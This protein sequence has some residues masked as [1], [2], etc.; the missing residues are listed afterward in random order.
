MFFRD[1]DIIRKGSSQY[2]D[3]WKFHDKIQAIREKGKTLSKEVDE[4]ADGFKNVH[5]GDK[6]FQIPWVYSKKHTL[7]FSL[8]YSSISDYIYKLNPGTSVIIFLSY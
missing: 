2:D 5:I 1:S 8:Q 7:P 6:E 3:F 4:K